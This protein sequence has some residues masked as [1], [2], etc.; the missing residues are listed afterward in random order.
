MNSIYS[1]DST[2]HLIKKQIYSCISAFDL[3]TEENSSLLRNQHVHYRG[4]SN[5]DLSTNLCEIDDS[6]QDEDDEDDDTVT[7]TTPSTTKS[8]KWANSVQSTQV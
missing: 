7:T 2:L 4:T 6:E 3:I 1:V 8:V 5:S